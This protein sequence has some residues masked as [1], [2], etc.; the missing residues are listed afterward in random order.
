MKTAD[1]RRLDVIL[2]GERRIQAIH[3]AIEVR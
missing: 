1:E 2:F 3:I